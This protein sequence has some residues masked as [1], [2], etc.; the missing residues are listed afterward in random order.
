MPVVRGLSIVVALV[1]ISVFILVTREDVQA[2]GGRLEGETGDVAL[3]GISVFLMFFPYALMVFVA[4]FG[5]ISLFR[6]YFRYSAGG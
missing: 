4:V 2:L 6:W 3:R 5:I 1:M